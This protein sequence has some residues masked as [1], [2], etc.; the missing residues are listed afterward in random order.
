ML[1]LRFESKTTT[2]CFWWEHLVILL[3]LNLTGG[4]DKLFET[5]L[6][7]K[8]ISFACLLGSGLNYIFHWWAQWLKSV[9]NSVTDLFMS[10]T[11][12]KRDVSSAKILHID[13][14]LSGI[15]FIQIRNKRGPSTDPCGTQELI[16][17]HPDVWPFKTTLCPRFWRVF[18]SWK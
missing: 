4:W 5:N 12:E 15:S 16:F 13:I 6:R 9:L 14:I 7:E 1:K 2:K 8:V 18:E 3:L 17:L 11:F 10:E